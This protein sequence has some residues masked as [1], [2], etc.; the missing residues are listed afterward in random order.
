MLGIRGRSKNRQSATI[1]QNI[2]SRGVRRDLQPTNLDPTMAYEILNY[3][4]EGEDVLVALKDHTNFSEN[5]TIEEYQ[6]FITI[7]DV[8]YYAYEG[9]SNTYIRK[10]E[11]AS[12]TS[13]ASFATNRNVRF[14][15]YGKFVFFV[16][17]LGHE[18]VSVIYSEGQFLKV[19]D[20]TNYQVNYTVEASTGGLGRAIVDYVDFDNNVLV[21][22]P[23]FSGYFTSG[24]TVSQPAI[25]STTT[26]TTSA[27]LDYYEM[28]GDDTPSADHIEVMSSEGDSRLV[29]FNTNLYGYGTSLRSHTDK[30]YGVPFTDWSFSVAASPDEGGLTTSS[31]L[32]TV[33]T[34][35]FYGGY[36]Y[37]FN[38]NGV[39]AWTVGVRNI[40]GV[41][42]TQYVDILHEEKR[43]DTFYDCIAGRNGIYYVSKSGIYQFVP[44]DVEPHRDLSLTIKKLWNTLDFSKAKIRSHDDKLFIN[45]IKDSASDNNYMLVYDLK[46]NRWTS[47]LGNFTKLYSDGDTL[48]GMDHTAGRV[49]TLFDASTYL[50]TNVTFREEDLGY[51]DYAKSLRFFALEALIQ[52][53]YSGTIYVDIWDEGNTKE[54]SY[55]NKSIVGYDDDEY[56]TFDYNVNSKP[57]RKFQISFE[58][59]NSTVNK[60][61]SLNV[62]VELLDKIYKNNV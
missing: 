60:F 54:E 53:T 10:K 8:S 34:V 56:G 25:P 57:I 45:C 52:D 19:A 59:N 6:D 15:K 46:Y 11:G 39:V 44:G 62:R 38:E 7:G 27:E 40:D 4:Y 2:V 3:E 12:E 37:Q 1:R 43:T 16:T 33:K 51:M 30:N 31:D 58:H 22:Q 47:A 48:Y 41:G 50:S 17:G 23:P 18:K 61:K 20:A 35:D 32:G 5:H 36:N 55:I 21:I 26:T 24:D 49:K 28:T 14:A 42:A 9:T 29:V 13:V